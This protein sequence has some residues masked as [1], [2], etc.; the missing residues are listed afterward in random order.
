MSHR[1][2]WPKI[3]LIKGRINKTFCRLTHFPLSFHIES[4]SFHIDGALAELQQS[5]KNIVFFQH[6][7]LKSLKNIVFFNI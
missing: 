7:S 3:R 2:Q 4:P 1:P 5:S 6:L